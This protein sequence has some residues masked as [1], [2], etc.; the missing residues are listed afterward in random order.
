MASDENLKSL[1]GDPRFAALIAKAK[2]K[3]Y[4]DQQASK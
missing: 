1:R 3:A 4:A 2:E